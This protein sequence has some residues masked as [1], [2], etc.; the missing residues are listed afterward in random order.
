MNKCSFIGLSF[1]GPAGGGSEGLRG[2]GTFAGGA[3]GGAR[4]AGEAGRAEKI[5]GGTAFTHTAAMQSGEPT[6]IQPSV[7]RR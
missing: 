5:S 3:T 7:L 4:E 6:G 1:L 2:A